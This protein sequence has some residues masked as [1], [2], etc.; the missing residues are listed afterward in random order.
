M[1]ILILYAKAHLEVLVTLLHHK[2]KLKLF[3]MC[4][5]AHL[6]EFL[7]I[8][9]EKLCCYTVWSFKSSTFT[10]IDMFCFLCRSAI[11][12]IQ[13]GV[14]MATQNGP[15]KG[16]T[17]FLSFYKSRINSDVTSISEWYTKSSYS[18][19]WSSHFC[20][21]MRCWEALT[22]TRLWNIAKI[23]LSNLSL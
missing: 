8:Y 14:A 3:F 22:Y 6:Q 19:L 4:L 16:Y 20:L 9:S 11:H 15:H 2:F 17:E 23:K 7:T 21:A 18:H 5:V 13:R 1:F 10:G 12:I